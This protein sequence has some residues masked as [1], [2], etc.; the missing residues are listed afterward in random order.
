M[1]I[2]NR[3][4]GILNKYFFAAF[5]TILFWFTTAGVLLFIRAQNLNNAE[6][7]VVSAEEAKALSSLINNSL[8]QPPIL[9]RKPYLSCEKDIPEI[10]ALSYVLADV[11]TGTIIA[12]KNAC[13]QIPPA[14]ITKLFSIYTVM[15]EIESGK[16]KEDT[17]IKPPRSAW[18][19]NMPAG[20]SLMFL[21]KNQLVSI[22]ELI[23]GMAVVSGNDAARALAL[24]AEGSEKDFVKKM[25]YYADKL[26]LKNTFFDESSGLSEKNITTAEDVTLF[27]IRY[28]Y[29][30]PENLRRFHSVTE[31]TYPQPHNKL[32]PQKSFTQKATNT[33]LKKL[34]GCDGLKTGFIY[35]SGFNISLTAKRGSTRFAAVI[36]GGKGNSKKEGIRI[37]DKNCEKLMNFAFSSFSTINLNPQKYLPASISVFGSN[38][39]S[40]KSALKPICVMKDFSNDKLTWYKKGKEL[41]QKVF[42]PRNLTAPIRMGQEI[43]KIVFYTENSEEVK[44]FSVIADRNIKEG[45]ALF[46]KID[47]II[48]DF[49]YLKN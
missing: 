11:Y 4:K 29:E 8:K 24:T 33:L 46:R 31:M 3:R 49:Q 27:S 6:A 42:L 2:Y 40:T 10:D 41:K 14:S 25:N 36:L 44:T 21:G 45:N 13:K 19:E 35:E 28:L 23:R 47:F 17:K 34:E 5:F 9:N 32:A 39:P 38:L 43:G 20:S 48:R 1:Y 26:K 12:E 7:P 15:K 16:I 18:A 37:R 30:Y 22:E